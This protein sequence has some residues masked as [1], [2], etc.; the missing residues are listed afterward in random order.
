MNA[1]EMIDSLNEWLAYEYADRE[2]DA[3]F[4]IA[5]DKAMEM[6]QDNPNHWANTEKRILWNRA[7]SLI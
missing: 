4:Y 6:I 3:A 1:L 5:F 7:Q 2:L